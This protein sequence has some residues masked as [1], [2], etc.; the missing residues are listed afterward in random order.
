MIYRKVSKMLQYLI[1]FGFF[2]PSFDLID[3]HENSCV[4]NI[5]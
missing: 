5:F 4:K 1:Y 3:S 2:V